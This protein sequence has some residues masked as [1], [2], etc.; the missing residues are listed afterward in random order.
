[1][2][3]ML[4]ALIV[5]HFT[6][7]YGLGAVIK[8]TIGWAKGWALLAIFPLIGCLNIRPQIIYRAA[9]IVSLHTIILTPVF[10]LAWKIGLPQVLYVSP[11]QKVGGPGPEFFAMS[12]YE[13]DPSNGSPRWRLF[14]PWAPAL[15]F[16]ANIYFVFALRDKSLFYRTVGIIGCIIM[17]L[18]SGASCT[19]FS[20]VHYL[21]AKY[22]GPTIYA[23]DHGH[24]HSIYRID[25]GAA[26]WIC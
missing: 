4:I 14:T 25:Y 2:I 21:V 22:D 6:N 1:M 13:I 26:T 23:L 3:V 16:V 5:G 19:D 18:L 24:R 7:D 8:S 15:G 12:L 10:I 11:V 20:I 17:V 9:C